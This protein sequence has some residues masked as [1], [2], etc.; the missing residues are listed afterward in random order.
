[1]EREIVQYS[2]GYY[3]SITIV[4]CLTRPLKTHVHVVY[5][6]TVSNE[7]MKYLH[8]FAAI[9]VSYSRV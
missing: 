7:C 4:Q 8:T 3:G 9:T 1:M 2:E 5:D 6:C